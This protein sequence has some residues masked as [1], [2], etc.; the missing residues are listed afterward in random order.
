VSSI[1]PE[2]ILKKL[3]ISRGFTNEARRKEFLNPDY[4]DLFNSADLPDMKAAVS[5]I[6]QAKR[7]NEK[8][9]IYGDY[10]V[11]GLTATTLLLDAFHKFG[12]ETTSYIPNRFT[13]GYGLSDT[14]VQHLADAGVKLIITVDCG[15]KSVAEIDKASELGVDVIVTDHHTLGE[16]LPKCIALVNPKRKDSKYQFK[17]LAGVGVAFKL[18]QAL[19][20]RMEGLE[21]GQEKWL[22]D[23]VALGTTCDIV[24]MTSENRVLVKWG[25]EVSRKSKRLAF[26]ALSSVSGNEKTEINTETFGFRF[27]PRLNVAGRLESAQKS[28]D[29]LT[30]KNPEDAMRLASELDLLN[31]ERRSEQTR[32][33]N[34][35]IVEAE[36]SDDGVLVLAGEDWS[37]G[38]VGIVAAKT[39]ERFKKP[40][41]ILQTI[42]ETTKGSAR[43]FGDFHL[44]QA[45]EELTG[46]IIGGGG[47]SMAAGV[48]L[49][50]NRVDEFRRKI[51]SY[52]KKLDLKNQACLLN[53][54][55]DMV[56]DNLSDV[57]SE[58][59][60]K[61]S[62]MEPFGLDNQKPVFKSKLTMVKARA[63]GTDATHLKAVLSDSDGVE[64]DAI[65]FGLAKEFDFT[66]AEVDVKY[67]IGLNT[68]N[69]QTSVQLELVEITGSN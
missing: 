48:T 39:V 24:S 65:G 36:A 37:Q 53:T 2:K 61:L 13:E 22:L 19:Q 44:A 67:R 60:E 26:G 27:G 8:I 6:K 12:I 58:L 43:S 54:K 66:S 64:I 34:E 16:V 57:N 29:L 11:D 3:L 25:I 45:L 59:V 31:T 32:I 56:L 7:N 46:I 33:F 38:V 5:R 63:V 14:G 35:V 15:S 17:E 69:N 1:L 30:S 9:C 51:N 41:F 47:H 55:I 28:L 42:G 50:T 52:Y 4:T 68:F 49:E 40:T 10:D 18:V 20:T 62:T 21:D 23:L